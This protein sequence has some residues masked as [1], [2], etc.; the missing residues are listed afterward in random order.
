MKVIKNR[1][2]NRL[3]LDCQLMKK[4]NESPEKNTENELEEIVDMI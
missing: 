3:E 2:C 1:L 4:V